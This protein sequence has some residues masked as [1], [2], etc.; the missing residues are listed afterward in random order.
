[1]PTSQAPML[2]QM[3]DDIERQLEL[4]GDSADLHELRAILSRPTQVAISER[5]YLLTML[6]TLS[7]QLDL[8]RNLRAGVIAS[9]R[10]ARPAP[11]ER[12]E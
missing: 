1:M 11:P 10:Q 2:L 12:H 6:K 8:I 5:T 7:E 9:I 4:A 3:I